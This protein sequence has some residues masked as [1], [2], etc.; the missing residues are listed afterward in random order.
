MLGL[1]VQDLGQGQSSLAEWYARTTRFIRT[2][3]MELTGDRPW[4]EIYLP[5]K[6]A[7]IEISD[8][9]PSGMFCPPAL[10]SLICARGDERC[11]LRNRNHILLLRT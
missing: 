8:M 6:S 10:Q 11:L 3:T 7:P 9:V 4:C 2:K 1:V 5:L